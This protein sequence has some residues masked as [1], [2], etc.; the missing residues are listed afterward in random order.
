MD[1]MLGNSDQQAATRAM[2][3]MLQMT[4]IDLAELQ[5]AFAGE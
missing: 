1:E 4:K 2:R 3:A 5:R